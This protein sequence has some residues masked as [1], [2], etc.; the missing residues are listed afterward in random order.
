[1]TTALGALLGHVTGGH[2]GDGKSSFQ[3]MNINFGLFPPI[4]APTHGAAG[5]R[6]KGEERGRAKRLALAERALAD[7]E[8]WLASA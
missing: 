1:V 8:G 3:P 4:A 7:L 5:K 6:L 2:I